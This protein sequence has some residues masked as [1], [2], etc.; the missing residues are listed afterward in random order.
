MA[1]ALD[2][3]LFYQCT[4]C[5]EDMTKR[6]PRLISCHH[7]FCE[8]CLQ[9]MTKRSD[10][11]CPICRHVTHVTSNDV[12]TLSL[13]FKLLTMKER[14]TKL[15]LTSR[16]MTLCQQCD[17]KAA[18]KNCS[19]CSKLLCDIC[20][21]KNNCVGLA[22]HTCIISDHSEHG[23]GSV[24]EKRKG[25]E[26]HL[27][28]KHTEIQPASE[29]TEITE[30]VEEVKQFSWLEKPKLVTNI[31]QTSVQ[32]DNP[33]YILCM[34]ND[35][36]AVAEWEGNRV[37]FINLS[38][39][40][41]KTYKI[42][43]TKGFIKHLYTNDSSDLF[44]VQGR[45]IVKYNISSSQDKIYHPNINGIGSIL[46]VDDTSKFIIATSGKHPTAI[47]EYEAE[48]DREKTI[49][50][51]LGYPKSIKLVKTTHEDYYISTHYCDRKSC[52]KIH[53]KHGALLRSIEDCRSDTQRLKQPRGITIVD[54]SILVCD[55][56]NH[57][58]CCFSIQG[59]LI[60]LIVT[61]ADG[62]RFPLAIDFKWPFLWLIEN[63]ISE[64]KA[65]KAFQIM[66]S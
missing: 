2:P 7:S 44:I 41:I 26:S 33:F 16:N 36:T 51:D 59:E 48:C 50:N 58:V 14:E 37:V 35:L 64:P 63:E 53:N 57:R 43:Q 47:Y 62:I 49:I 31:S 5:F 21:L 66:K 12:T 6:K 55:W 61:E 46:Y 15:S 11:T 13:D 20:M 30:K 17:G 34:K 39:Q 40:S 42:D 45:C 8:E 22:C 4:I 56:M 65:I 9:K 25:A 32:L 23:S 24:Q 27:Q 28:A 54:H 29:K 52:I 1:E 60:H 10:I 18:T 3:E 38:G 19:D